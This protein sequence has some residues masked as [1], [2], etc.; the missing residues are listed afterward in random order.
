MLCKFTFCTT[1]YLPCFKSPT[2][3]RIS[4][5]WLQNVLNMPAHPIAK[6]SFDVTVL[7]H[8]NELSL[9]NNWTIGAPAWVV[10]VGNWGSRHWN[11]QTLNDIDSRHPMALWRCATKLWRNRLKS[12]LCSCATQ[13]LNVF[14]QKKKLKPTISRDIVVPTT[15]IRSSLRRQNENI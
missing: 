3:N 11:T 14:T 9:N 15:T 4:A 13:S 5:V 2:F 1:Q 12:R 7:D 6:M 10:G 8:L